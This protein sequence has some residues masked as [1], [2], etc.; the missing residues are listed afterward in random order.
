VTRPPAARALAAGARGSGAT[1]KTFPCLLRC[2]TSVVSC[3][4]SGEARIRLPL[5]RR[6]RSVQVGNA[7]NGR[8][9]KEKNNGAEGWGRWTAA[10]AIDV[11]VMWVWLCNIIAGPFARGS[12]RVRSQSKDLLQIWQLDQRDCTIISLWDAGGLAILTIPV[13]LSYSNDK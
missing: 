10:F 6:L 5:L 2:L 12:P 1:R 7:R 3:E 4:C 11:D 8:W 9:S 13:E